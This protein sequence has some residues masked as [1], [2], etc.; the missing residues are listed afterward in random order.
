MNGNQTGTKR[1]SGLA[2]LMWTLSAL[3]FGYAF[4]HRVAPSVMV[5]DLMRDFAIGGALLGTLSALYFYPYVL[6]QIPLGA[7]L[8][9]LGARRLLTIALTVAGTGSILFGIAEDVILAYAGRILIGT[10]C[11]VGFLGSLT[12]AA[13]WFPPHRFAFLAGLV[14]FFGMTSGMLAQAPLALFVETFGWRASMWALASVGLT[15]AALIFVF[16]RNAPDDGAIE[17]PSEPASFRSVWSGLKQAASSMEVW[18][19]AIVASTMS[20]PMLTIG[21][22]W[23]T[24][25]MMVAYGLERPQAAGLVSLLLLGW[26]VGAP[27]A[28]WFSDHIGKRKALLV[29]GGLVLCLALAMLVF[30]PALPLWLATALLVV[31]GLSGA[32]MAVCF[33]LVREVS[34]KSISG[35]VT[36]IVNSMT[37]ASGA[38][39]QP[40]VGYILDLVWNGTIVD[41]SRIY[42]AQDYRLA[43]GMI[44]ATTIIG[45]L[46]AL[47]LR[48]SSLV[49]RRRS[50]SSIDVKGTPN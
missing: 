24:P 40:G 2:W 5:S 44:L 9:R 19:I 41:G 47:T 39:L 6:L 18:K 21:G 49:R 35:S 14:M 31:L 43:F 23:G 15:L 38:V 30:V 10:G 3:A 45:L 37:V 28:G 36:G 4:F 26:A 46:I 48:E 29:A 27:F 1:G 8:D 7:L 13:N 34:D 42:Q 20:G 25:Y 22:L 11:A 17:M 12:L 16:V 50:L 32:A 33:A